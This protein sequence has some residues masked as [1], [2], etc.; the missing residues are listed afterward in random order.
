MRGVGVPG[1]LLVAGVTAV[2]ILVS[3]ERP[4]A[5]A[6]EPANATAGAA[7]NAAPSQDDYYTRRAKGI[8]KAEKAAWLEPHPLAAAYPGMD[9]VVCE[10]GCPDRSSAQVVSVRRHVEM[11]ETTEGSMIP[12]SNDG[13]GS[14]VSTASVACIAGCYGE[15]AGRG[16][17]L[18]KRRAAQPARMT[19]PVRDKL[20]P[21][22]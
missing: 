11:T 7:G 21:V 9:I 3:I 4:A 1:S 12:T 20:S 18:L 13:A 14:A 2:A 10:A 8:L 5:H 19:L 15:N 17:E 22:R 16:S 6:A